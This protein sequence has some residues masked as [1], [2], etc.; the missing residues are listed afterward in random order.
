M[1][2]VALQSLCLQMAPLLQLDRQA[3][4]RVRSASMRLRGGLGCSVVQTSMVRRA[5]IAVVSQY[6][7]LKMALISQSV[8]RAITLVA[9]TFGS[10][11]STAVPTFGIRLEATSMATQQETKAAA[12]CLCPRMA[13][14]WPLG[15]LVAASLALR[16]D[17]PEY[18]PWIAEFGRNRAAILMAKQPTTTVARRCL[19]SQ[20]AAA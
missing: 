16:R 12:R 3:M 20:V 17:R 8:H 9:V 18:L 2:K 13:P 10:I 7:C 11:A 1:T 5:T 4:G 19:W 14:L 6:R 15:R